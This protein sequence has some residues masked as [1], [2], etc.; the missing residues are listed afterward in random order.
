MMRIDYM[1]KIIEE[2]IEKCNKLEE[3]V[4]NANFDNLKRSQELKDSNRIDKKEN[5]TIYFLSLIFLAIAIIFGFNFLFF[6]AATINLTMMGLHHFTSINHNNEKKNYSK[7]QLKAFYY[8]EN[9]KNE[10]AKKIDIDE[11][12][13]TNISYEEE[14]EQFNEISRMMFQ[15]MIKN[16]KIS[17]LDD[18]DIKKLNRIESRSKDEVDYVFNQKIK[19]FISEKYNKIYTENESNLEIYNS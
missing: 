15:D 10:M 5:K 16:N 3:K 12:I 8:F 1:G 9:N 18:N 2:I 17:F 14:S 4:N 11:V 6:M 19:D 13:S 7:D